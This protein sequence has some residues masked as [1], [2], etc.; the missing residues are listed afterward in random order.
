MNWGGCVSGRSRPIKDRFLP[1]YWMMLESLVRLIWW[2]TSAGLMRKYRSMA[3]SEVV[4]RSDGIVPC[5][6]SA[7]YHFYVRRDVYIRPDG[8]PE[9]V[10]TYFV[11]DV[12]SGSKVQ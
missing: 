12:Q 6:P 11:R 3:H 5:K 4:E 10:C 8:T 2:I 7:R 9:T 1:N